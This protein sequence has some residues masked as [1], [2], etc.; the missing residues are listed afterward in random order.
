MY[1]TFNKGVGNARLALSTLFRTCAEYPKIEVIDLKFTRAFRFS[2][3]KKTAPHFL[4]L[5][6]LY[7]YKT[8]HVQFLIFFESFWIWKLK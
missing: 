3:T 4:N 1:I 5:C 8:C 7:V 2:F 6:M